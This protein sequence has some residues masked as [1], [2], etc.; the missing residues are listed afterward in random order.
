MIG[1]KVLPGRL[2][3]TVCPLKDEY[4]H[5]GDIIG[6]YYLYSMTRK[7]F[8]ELAMRYSHGG[9]NPARVSVIYDNLMEEAG[10]PPLEN[11]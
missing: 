2:P 7:E 4:V 8:I 9:M 10:L 11:E 5:I 3:R 6:K 1:Y